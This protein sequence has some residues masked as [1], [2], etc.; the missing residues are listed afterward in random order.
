M[1]TLAFGGHGGSGFLGA[2]KGSLGVACHCLFCPTPWLSPSISTCPLFFLLPPLFPSP[3]SLLLSPFSSS[4]LPIFPFVSSPIC[5]TFLFLCPP[6]SSLSHPV[7][8][9]GQ[10]LS[11]SAPSEGEEG[12]VSAYPDLP[13]V[14]FGLPPLKRFVSLEGGD[15]WADFTGHSGSSG[16]EE[17]SLQALGLEQGC[18]GFS[19]LVEPDWPKASPNC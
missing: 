6:P 5:S 19:G 12:I 7:S 1:G 3:P 13:R 17:P 18:W 14:S 16:S 9:L 15:S 10:N 2:T 8:Y 4:H 11:P